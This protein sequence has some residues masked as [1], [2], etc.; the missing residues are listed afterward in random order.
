MKKWR[1]GI[2]GGALAVLLFSGTGIMASEDEW[3]YGA[4]AVSEGE[5]Y[6]VEEMLLY[7]IQD[8]Y[9]AEA[10]YDAIMEAYG[11]VKPFTNIAKAEGTHISLLLPLFETYGLEVPENEAVEYIELPASLAESFEEGVAG[12]IKNIAIYEQFLQN[13]ELPDDVRSVFERLMA[14]S[15]NHLAAFERGVTGNPD[16]AGR[17]K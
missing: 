6:S 11:T 12:E 10:S 14:A 16:G 13:E 7:A 2:V 5:T 8:E 9:M 4:A 17:K 1:N 15:E 3:E